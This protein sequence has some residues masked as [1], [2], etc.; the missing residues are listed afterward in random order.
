MPLL[1]SRSVRLLSANGRWSTFYDGRSTTSRALNVFLAR[2][3]SLH[4]SHGHP[5]G[6]VR[7]MAVSIA[8]AGPLGGSIESTPFRRGPAAGEG[9]NR[10][11]LYSSTNPGVRSL[12]SSPSHLTPSRPACSLPLLPRGLKLKSLAET[13]FSSICRNLTKAFPL[14][15]ESWYERPW[16]NCGFPVEPPRLLV[17][18]FLQQPSFLLE[19]D[20]HS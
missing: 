1:R 18:Q 20:L 17:L 5:K 12:D 14:V 15:K 10:Y 8:S 19:A 11:F 4:F 3:N 9:V 6:P 2:L 7:I 16:P 13:P